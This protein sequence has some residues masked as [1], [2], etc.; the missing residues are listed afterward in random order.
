MRGEF[1]LGMIM[2]FQGLMTAFMMPVRTIISASRTI[3]EMRNDMERID[4]V[5]EYPDDVNCI[6][7]GNSDDRL[8]K[9]WASVDTR[10]LNKHKAGREYCVCRCYGVWKV[11][12]LEFITT[13]WS[14]KGVTHTGWRTAGAICRAVSVRGLKL[15]GYWHRILRLWYSMRQRAQMSLWPCKDYMR[16]L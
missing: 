7:L 6:E 13:L 16:I 15:R 14:V 2:T 12:G 9:A 4:D 10:L 11:D 8:F 3:Q 1:T 5:M